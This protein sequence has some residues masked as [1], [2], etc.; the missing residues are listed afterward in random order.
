MLCRAMKHTQEL[1]LK[2]HEKN[3]SSKALTD[4][5]KFGKFVAQQWQRV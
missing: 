2:R 1:A 5:S 3:K 4:I